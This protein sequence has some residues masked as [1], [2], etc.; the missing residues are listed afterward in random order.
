MFQWWEL[1]FN[2]VNQSNEAALKNNLDYILSKLCSDIEKD[3][4]NEYAFILAW[5]NR[6]ELERFLDL[7]KNC[8]KNSVKLQFVVTKN[9]I[10]DYYFLN[11][12]RKFIMAEHNFTSYLKNG[13][14]LWCDQINTNFVVYVVS[15]DPKATELSRSKGLITSYSTEEIFHN[16]IETDR[17]IF[18]QQIFAVTNL[19]Q[20]ISKSNLLMVGHNCLMD[21]MFVYS[22]FFRSLPG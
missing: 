14:K 22:S 9:L 16:I 19:F 18:K 11:Q 21:L 7:E 12:I 4:A 10:Y 6:L 2:Y 5:L 3:I 13:Q 20:Y 1:G 8:F 15:H 17:D